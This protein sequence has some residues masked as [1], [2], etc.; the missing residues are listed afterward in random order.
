M[1]STFDFKQPRCFQNIPLKI[2]VAMHS[3]RVDH[4]KIHLWKVFRASC[5]RIGVSSLLINVENL[6]ILTLQHSH[7]KGCVIS[8]FFF[9]RVISGAA[10]RLTISFMTVWFRL[11]VTAKTESYTLI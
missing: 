8:S 7:Q 9:A 3:I 11:Q 6:G 5:A 4:P 1:L 2:Y 10:V